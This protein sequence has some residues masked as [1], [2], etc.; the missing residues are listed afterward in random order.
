M[1]R[2]EF[3]KGAVLGAALLSSGKALGYDGV[4]STGGGGLLKLSDRD[5]P[6]PM[7][8]GHVPAIE[9]PGQVKSGEWF[10]AKVKV[11]FM[12]EH[13][14]LPEHWITFI[15]LMANGDEIVKAEY[16]VGGISAS[17][18]TFKIKIEEETRFQAIAHCNL[19]GTWL[20]DPITVAVSK[21]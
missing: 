3:I 21:T 14:S 17:Y 13:P 5:N 1:K 2:R 18:A 7:E 8:Q 11:G 16:D 10:D 4:E 9:A 19:H 15:K 12:K 6:S 20:S